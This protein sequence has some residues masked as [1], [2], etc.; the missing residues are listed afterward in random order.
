MED[1]S[2]MLE[3]ISAQAQELIKSKKPDWFDIHKVDYEQQK[4]IWDSGI[5]GHKGGLDGLVE[6][7]KPDI[8]F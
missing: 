8:D 3:Q 4:Q 6:Y 2:D 1:Q 7:S 5:K